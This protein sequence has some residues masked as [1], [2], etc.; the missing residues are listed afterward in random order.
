[1][2]ISTIHNATMKILNTLVGWEDVYISLLGK[3]IPIK[4]LISKN[5]TEYQ[6]NNSINTKDFKLC[7]IMVD[8][9]VE[10]NKNPNLKIPIP[11]Q[12]LKAKN[13]NIIVSNGTP[14]QIK[15]ESTGSFNEKLIWV[16]EIERDI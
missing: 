1:M 7:K 2:S 4:A 3:K 8:D 6:R 13:A 14:Y 15:M 16:L 11:P 12:S 9:I 10:L 5:E